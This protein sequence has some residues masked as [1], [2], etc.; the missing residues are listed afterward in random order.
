MTKV[1]NSMEFVEE[2]VNSMV[3]FLGRDT[4]E[5]LASE[6]PQEEKTEEEKL[7]EGPQTAAQAQ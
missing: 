1:V 7:L 4:I 3:E 6:L 2:R 5:K